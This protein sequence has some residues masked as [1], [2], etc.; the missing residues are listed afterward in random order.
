MSE[1]T[2][3]LSHPFRTLHWRFALSYMIVTVLA[4]AMVPLLYFA[5]SYLFVVR[6]SD[7]PR[8]MAAG[9][10]SVA[11]QTLPFILHA[12]PD[13]AGLHTWLA[14]FNSN[15]RVQSTGSFA[16]LWMS[17]PPYGSSTLAV[18]D[19]DG[20]VIATTSAA[21]GQPGAL[22]MP[23]LAPQA[24]QVVRAALAGDTRPSDLAAPT[25]DG[26]SEVAIPIA[27]GTHVLGALVLD[28]DV[29]ATQEA[30]LPRAFVGLF[31]FV[32]TLV[33]V[34]GLIGLVFGFVISRGL[35][36]RLR[37]ITR[38]AE[39]WSRGDFSTTARDPSA[40][41]LGQLARDLNR[42][43]EQ[44]QTLIQDQQQLAVMEERNRLARDLHDSV[45]QQVFATAMQVAA[46]RALVRQDPA[47]AEGRLA[48]VERLVGEAQR[49]LTALIGELRPAALA[50][51]GLAPAL[52]EYCD[53][54]SRRT[55]I[56][57]EVRVQG[58]QPASLEVEQALFRVAQEAL[59]NVARH[60]GA[61][62]AE[63]RLS[64]EPQALLLTITD[65]GSG[66]DAVAAAGKGVGLQSMRERVEA[67]GGALALRAA[68]DGPGARVEACA[69]L[70]RVATLVQGSADRTIAGGR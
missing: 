15:G 63:V 51:K 3:R 19:P 55:G 20:R 52:R 12:P 32:A 60:S 68:P 29:Q 59:A 30:Y 23:R 65:N 49:E 18:L 43:A 56:A 8:S 45:K 5:T 50:N 57:A 21:T 10:Q 37:R 36:Q 69:P 13:Q 11:P 1:L 44:L 9:L 24:Q 53:A 42:M 34:T 62:S 4:V 14:D 25:R 46:A 67:I 61:T 27:E 38:A 39:A 2:R 31:G 70:A 22:L 66:F 35:A 7:L 17:G 48:E 40:D 16:D 58:E 41:E 28:M 54:W 6:T 26:R 47:A 33:I 64:W